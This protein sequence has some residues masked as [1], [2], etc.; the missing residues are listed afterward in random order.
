MPKYIILAGVTSSYGK[1]DLRQLA[2]A[3]LTSTPGC[4]VLHVM[5]MDEPADQIEEKGRED[6][7]GR[8]R[9]ADSGNDS[10]SPDVEEEDA[11]EAGGAE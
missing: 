5:V 10:R 9:E 4:E 3:A 11:E 6:S 8:E 7:Y 2:S 1:G